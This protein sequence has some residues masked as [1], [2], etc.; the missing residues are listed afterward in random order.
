MYSMHLVKH[1]GNAV[2]PA[3]PKVLTDHASRLHGHLNLGNKYH[4]CF[5]RLNGLSSICSAY[6]G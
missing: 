1:I 3:D 4:Y 2:A 5:L 6:C